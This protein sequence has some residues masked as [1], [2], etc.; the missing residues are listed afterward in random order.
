MIVQYLASM[1]VMDLSRH[2]V[3]HT[4]HAHRNTY[5][6]WTKMCNYL[7]VITYK[8]KAIFMATN[9]NAYRPYQVILEYVILDNLNTKA[10]QYENIS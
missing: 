8:I 3:T 1:I 7:Q 2:T 9:A 5:L 6:E 10:R 4:S